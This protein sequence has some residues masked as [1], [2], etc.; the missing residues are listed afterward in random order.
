MK[1]QI[2]AFFDPLMEILKRI[3]TPL[4]K[5]K[6]LNGWATQFFRIHGLLAMAIFPFCCYFTMEFIHYSSTTKFLSFIENRRTAVEFGITLIYI[7]YA[8]LLLILKKGWLASGL[9]GA[10]TIIISMSNYYKFAQVGD[11]LY[12]WDIVQQTGNLGELSQFLGIPFPWWGIVL[13]CGLAYLVLITF[14]S[15]LELPLSFLVRLPFIV[16]I[17][18]GCTSAVDTPEKATQVLNE[19]TLYF[20]DMALQ[21]SNYSANGFVGAFTVNIL[22][23]GVSEPENYSKATVDDLMA[24]YKATPA[25]ENF[26]NPDIILILS[27]SFWDPTLLPGVEFSSD[28]LANFREIAARENSISGKFYTTGFGGGTVRPEFEVLTGLT[29]DSLPGGSVPW[30]YITKET[31]SYVSIYK[32]L[33]Y[34]TMAVHPYTSSFYLRKQGYPYIGIDE[35]YFEDIM[36]QFAREKVIP[37]TISGKQIADTSFIDYIKYFMNRS[38]EDTFVFGISMENHQPYS[39]KFDHFDI[40]LKSETI[41]ANLL[42]DVR[43]YT[44]GVYEADLALKKL[45]DWIDTREKETILVYFGDHLP[46]LGG[47]YAA[48]N[49]SGAISLDGM[50]PEM[51]KFLYSTPFLVYANYELEESEMLKVG[52]DNEIASYNLMNAVATLIDAPRTQYMGFLED[53]FKAHPAY[54]VRLW[55]INKAP[56][57]EFIEAHKIITYDRTVGG[58]YS[59]D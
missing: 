10:A 16:I 26:K 46:T 51:N 6:S 25:G 13:Y 2:I 32:D 8:L 28:P 56:F 33:G 47:N 29:T 27:E 30:Q 50:T 3:F 44:Q 40:E 48:Y 49:Q 14:I 57:L 21:T 11:Y 35:L 39:N 15:K 34:R 5:F 1:K 59:L 20:E 54:N 7:L 4:P 45:V 31:E 18:Y 42:S 55:S 43:N 58:R 37:M 53:Y 52:S 17:M 36:Y 19:N 12:P 23:S 24:L 22:S 9:M 41:D 38:T